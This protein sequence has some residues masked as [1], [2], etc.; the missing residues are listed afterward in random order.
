MFLCHP[1][2]LVGTVRIRLWLWILLSS[3]KNSKKNLD[4]TVLLLLYDFLSLK[5][6]VNVTSKSNKQK[7][8]NFVVVDVLKVTDEKAGSAGSASPRYGIRGFG[9]L[10]KC[11][12]SGTLFKS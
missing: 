10:P 1:D 12:G 3:S 5:N 7:N 2:P 9:S 4:S 6:E 11:H 8:R